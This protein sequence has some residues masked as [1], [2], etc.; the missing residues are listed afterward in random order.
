MLGAIALGGAK[1]YSD[2]KASEAQ[3]KAARVQRQISA[4]KAAAQRRQLVREAGIA[5]GNVRAAAGLTGTI[6]SSRTQQGVGSV[7]NQV[8]GKFALENRVLALGDKASKYLQE[9]ANFQMYSSAFSAA[10]TAYPTGG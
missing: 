10:A 7:A 5:A 2:Y 4:L 1:L 9:A 8:G 3:Q 6:N